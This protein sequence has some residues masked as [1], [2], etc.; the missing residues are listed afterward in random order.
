MA[1]IQDDRALVRGFFGHP[2]VAYVKEALRW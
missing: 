1:M 2:A